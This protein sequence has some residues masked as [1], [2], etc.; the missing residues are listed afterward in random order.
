[1]TLNGMLEWVDTMR[2]NPFTKSQKTAWVNDLEAGLWQNILLQ[3]MSLW[4]PKSAEDGAASLLLP[5]A[6]RR[7]YT[8]YL[9]AMM[10]FALGEFSHYE[11]SMAQYNAALAELGAWYAREYAPAEN[12][13]R[14][15]P[16]VAVTGGRAPET[17]PVGRLPEGAAALGA[18]CRVEEA[19]APDCR[20]ALGTEAEPELFLRREEINAQTPGLYRRLGLR[21]AEEN[22]RILIRCENE[23]DGQG[24]LFLRLLVQLPREKGERPWR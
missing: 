22:W 2:P 9:T 14:W 6:W 23:E 21:L 24:K 4:R 13:A 17:G 5:A 12:P 11:N 8:A 20:I 15:L 10:D 16:W 7:L 19:F 3:S 18:E 1:M